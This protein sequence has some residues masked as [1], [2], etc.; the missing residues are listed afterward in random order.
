MHSTHPDTTGKKSK[1]KVLI[2]EDDSD[3]NKFL[4]YLFKKMDFEVHTAFDGEEGLAAA[5]SGRPDLVILD[6]RLPKFPGEEVCKAIRED[7]D[8]AFAKT[9]IVMLTGKTADV[10]RVIGNVIGA[11]SYLTKPFRTADLMEQVKRLV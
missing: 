8:K 6:L 7:R 11:S 9:P 2:V 1:K 4:S 5:R 10:D 3:L